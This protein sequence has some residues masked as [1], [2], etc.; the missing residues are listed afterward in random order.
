MVRGWPGYRVGLF[1]FGFGSGV[2]NGVRVMR[3]RA[4]LDRGDL[5]LEILTPARDREAGE[6]FDWLLVRGRAITSW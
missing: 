4:G 3:V 6:P 1:G 5:A 2:R